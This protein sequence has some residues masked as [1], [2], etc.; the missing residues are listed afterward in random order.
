MLRTLLLDDL[1]FSR[2]DHTPFQC[3]VFLKKYYTLYFI[4]FNHLDYSPESCTIFDCY[5]ACN[6]FLAGPGERCSNNSV[7]E[8][9][10]TLKLLVCIVTMF[11]EL[12]RREV[13]FE[14]L[15]DNMFPIKIISS[16]SWMNSWSLTI[17]VSVCMTI[18]RIHL[19]PDWLNVK[20]SSHV[21][22]YFAISVIADKQAVSLEIVASVLL[23]GDL[24]NF[25]F[26]EIRNE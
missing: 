13:L 6:T 1:S 18:P 20:I 8:K 24:W 26:S 19:A 14:S 21:T 10:N 12:T 15:P 2:R 5:N 17:V 22:I 3:Y 16:Y 9:R 25:L 4:I 23:V 11:S 7:E